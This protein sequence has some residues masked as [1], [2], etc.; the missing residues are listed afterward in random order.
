[1]TPLHQQ[2]LNLGFHRE[3]I[4]NAINAVDD[5]IN[6]NAIIEQIE[7]E[8]SKRISSQKATTEIMKKFTTKQ[9]TDHLIYGYVH[10]TDK[11]KVMLPDLI[12]IIKTYHGTYYIA[13]WM[14]MTIKEISLLSVHDK[15]DHRDQVGRFVYGTIAEKDGNNL[16][17]HYDGWQRKW[18]SWSNFEEEYHRF[19]VAGSISKRPA[20]RFAALKRGDY[21]DINPTQ[22]HPGWKCG[23]IRRLDQK[24][25]Q[26][27]V[28][29]EFG[30]KNYLYWA[31]RD[32]EAE[33]AEF[34]SKAAER[35]ES[36]V[37]VEKITREEQQRVIGL[38]VG[39]ANCNGD[40][41]RGFL[42]ECA[43]NLETAMSKFLAFNDEKERGK[44]ELIVTFMEMTHS[45]EAVAGA[46]MRATGWEMT[47]A[48]NR[49][50]EFE[51]DASKLVD[52]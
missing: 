40:V 6:V 49:F 46:F 10:S 8:E 27:Q 51:G 26:V 21:V 20:N 18:D 28:V 5:K 43:W 24:S 19:A 37:E 1:M 4:T 47:K 33:I 22:R 29:Y 34:T 44:R 42:K 14:I 9:I 12:Q 50:F 7:R 23:E 16:K 38:F 15:I 3:D 11:H 25:G 52:K 35:V 31:H 39:M 2:L 48:I 32:N 41:A 45:D 17:I 36:Q 30:D 13:G